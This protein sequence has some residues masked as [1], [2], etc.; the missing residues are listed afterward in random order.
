M[1]SLNRSLLIFFSLTKKSRDNLPT[2]CTAAQ[3]SPRDSGSFRL[4]HP[5]I[6]GQSF[7]PDDGKTLALLLK[8]IIPKIKKQQ[9]NKNK[10]VV[11]QEEERMVKRKTHIS[12]IYLS[13]Q[14]SCRFPKCPTQQISIFIS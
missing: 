10:K 1:T 13:F 4:P 7:V 8:V 6:L 11:M 9:Q 12:S 14:E 5:L 2:A 3:G